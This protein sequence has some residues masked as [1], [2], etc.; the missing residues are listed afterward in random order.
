[1]LEE[2]KKLQEEKDK[3][4][5]EFRKAY[6]QKCKEYNDKLLELLPYQDRYIKITDDV[7]YCEPQY[8]KVREIFKHGNNIVIRG[9]GFTGE[10]TEYADATWFDWSYMTSYDFEIYQIED[11]VKCIE[12]I[13]ESE[14]TNAF[15]RLINKIK[16]AHLNTIL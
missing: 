15:N 1:M 9:Y 6:D 16:S 14:F 4:Y 7:I 5:D 11:K 10:F 8:I 13:S 12:I 3:A 2:I